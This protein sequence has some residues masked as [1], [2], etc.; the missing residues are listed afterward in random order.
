MKTDN[1]LN[2]NNPQLVGVWPGMV[3]VAI[4]AGY[5]LMAKLGMRML[6]EMP[7]TEYFDLDHV[8]V[9]RGL[10]LTSRRAVACFWNDPARKAISSSLLGS[11]ASFQSQRVLHEAYRVPIIG[12]KRVF[13]FAAMATQMH[14]NTHRGF[15]SF[16]DGETLSESTNWG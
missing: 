16:I 7:A 2:L 15:S 3:A 9:N 6:E 13:T 1:E 4:S 12:M 8:D 5:Y 11:P 14:P 10:I